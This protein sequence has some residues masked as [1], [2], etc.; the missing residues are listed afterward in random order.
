MRLGIDTLLMTICCGKI[1]AAELVLR[2]AAMVAVAGANI[3]D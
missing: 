1:A 3:T 2:D